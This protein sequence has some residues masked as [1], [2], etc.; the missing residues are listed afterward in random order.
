[1]ECRNLVTV[2]DT[3][4]PPLPYM[5]QVL[6]G[7][8]KY[9]IWFF[10]DSFEKGQLRIFQKNCKMRNTNEELLFQCLSNSDDLIGSRRGM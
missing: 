4:G 1:M 2:D 5:E 9:T 10:Q 8:P 3:Y 7:P 6:Y